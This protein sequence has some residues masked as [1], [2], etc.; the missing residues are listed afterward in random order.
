MRM[1]KPVEPLPPLPDAFES[2]VI[3]EYTL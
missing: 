1:S 3:D 2:D